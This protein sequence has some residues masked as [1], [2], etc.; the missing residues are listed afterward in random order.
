MDQ[1]RKEVLDIYTDKIIE[2]LLKK[3]LNNR[4]FQKALNGVFDIKMP[5]FAV[6]SALLSMRQ[7]TELRQLIYLYTA[8]QY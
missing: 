5:L 6:K 2:M 1:T 3:N 8:K 4:Q 7:H